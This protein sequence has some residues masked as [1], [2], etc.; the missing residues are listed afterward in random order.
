MNFVN[1]LSLWCEN[2][3]GGC[4]MRIFFS[5]ALIG[6]GCLNASNMEAEK[7]MPVNRHCLALYQFFWEQSVTH[8]VSG[9]LML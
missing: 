2:V 4:L 9:V 8:L 5:V 7:I 6:A 1:N 3:G